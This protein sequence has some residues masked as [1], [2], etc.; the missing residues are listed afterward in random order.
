RRG[1]RAAR[2]HSTHASRRIVAAAS[3]EHAPGGVPAPNSE[4]RYG[5][6]RRQSA[7]SSVLRDTR[8]RAARAPSGAPE[9]TP[10]PAAGGDRPADREPTERRSHPDVVDRVATRIR[11]VKHDRG[12]RDSDPAQT[13]EQAKSGRIVPR[14]ERGGGHPADTALRV[15]RDLRADPGALPLAHP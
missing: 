6:P 14:E 3:G 2:R 9:P 7:L 10:P 5:P 12:D 11:E 15:P 8:W 1:P 13:E 4:A